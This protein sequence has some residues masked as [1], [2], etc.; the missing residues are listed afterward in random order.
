MTFGIIS[1]KL[2][3]IY[4]PLSI[5]LPEWSIPPTFRPTYLTLPDTPS[6]LNL[7]PLTIQPNRPSA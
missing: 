2:S 6:P 3:M 1:T 4:Y 7:R 5:D